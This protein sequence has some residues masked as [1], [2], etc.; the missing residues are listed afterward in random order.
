MVVEK[1]YE[2]PLPH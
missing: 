2:P 1:I